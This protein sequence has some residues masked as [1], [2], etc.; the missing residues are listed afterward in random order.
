MVDDRSVQVDFDVHR[1]EGQAV[2]CVVRALDQ[3]FGTVG[4]L[5][6][7]IPASPEGSVHRQVTVRTTTRA[8]TGV[9]RDCR[10]S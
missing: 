3:A 8:V 9:V 6:V 1:P 10:A 7:R 2:T 4:T 5:E